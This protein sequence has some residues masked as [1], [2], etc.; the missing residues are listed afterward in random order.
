MKPNI[1]TIAKMAG[2]SISTVSKITNNYS[3][4]SEETK[5]RVLEIMKQTGYVPSN[6]AKTLATKRSNLI[7]VIFAGK[8]NV[9]F[10]HPF[11][12]EVLNAF[13]K[14]MGFLGYDL[15]FFSNEKF[16][17]SD[18]DYLARSLHFQV[19]G[20][21]IISGEE[22]EASIE[23]L[24]LSNIPCIGVDIQLKGQN[25]GTIMSDNY[26]MSAKV[27]EHFYMLGYKELGYIGSTLKSNISNLR[28][29]GYRD[30][31]ETLSLQVN[32]NW[33]V[34]GET[35]FEESGYE[36]M[37]RLIKAG[38]LPRAIFAASDLLAIGAMRAMKEHNLQVPQDIAIIGCDDID[39]CKYT[40]P[41]LSTIR[42]NKEKIGILSARMLFDLINN[43]SPSNAF[44]VD[45]ELIVRESCGSHL[46]SYGFK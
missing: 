25:S 19:D 38:K 14:Q 45:P 42:Q 23:E 31:I 36:A 3:D 4:V 39:A 15:L 35:F 1:K 20:C 13:K 21:I 18:G 2:V 29:S 46:N 12:I 44:I 43:Q 26:K 37:K 22:V 6:S 10:T 30:A 33:F 9:D 11:F 41:A 17:G 40:S 7:G 27:V 34:N 5:T 28:E 24:D 32:A 8:I 16:H